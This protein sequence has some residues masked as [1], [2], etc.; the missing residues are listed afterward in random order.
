MT[1]LRVLD[2]SDPAAITL[3]GTRIAGEVVITHG[4]LDRELSI[5]PP[6]MT[7]GGQPVHG[8][9][10]VRGGHPVLVIPR[11]GARVW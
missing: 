6:A 8:V 4:R 9:A 2:I 10:I 1:G 5:E 3:D 7:I 11:E